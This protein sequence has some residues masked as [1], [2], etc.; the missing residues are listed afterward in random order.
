MAAKMHEA[1]HA[2]DVIHVC[3]PFAIEAEPPQRQVQVPG[4]PETSIV[5][6]LNRDPAVEG[7][8]RVR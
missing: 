1:D 7:K 3:E 8:R 2:H 6:S 5:P 4:M